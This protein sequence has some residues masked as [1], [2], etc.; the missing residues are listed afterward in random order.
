MKKWIGK[1]QRNW[2]NDSTFVIQEPASL[3]VKSSLAAER[4]EQSYYF[5]CGHLNVQELDRATGGMS[6]DASKGNQNK[7]LAQFIVVRNTVS[8]PNYLYIFI[9]ISFFFLSFSL[10]STLKNQSIKKL[11]VNDSKLAT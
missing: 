6:M 9:I 7:T 3:H 2:Q 8:Q 10:Y 1:Q 11:Q 4:V 5:V